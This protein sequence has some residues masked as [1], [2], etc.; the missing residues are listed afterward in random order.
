MLDHFI[1]GRIGIES[2]I[3]ARD[4]A[5]DNYRKEQPLRKQRR[6]H[7]E[8][9]ERIANGWPNSN[10]DALGIGANRRGTKGFGFLRLS[11]C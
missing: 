6:W 10:T 5:A 8:M 11:Q 3:V 1:A 9:G 4:Q 2:N 7:T